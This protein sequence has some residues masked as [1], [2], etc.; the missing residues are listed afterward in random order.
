M[1]KLTCTLDFDGIEEAKNLADVLALLSR[2]YVPSFRDAIP[3][4]L[5]SASE[6]LLEQDENTDSSETAS[7]EN[8]ANTRVSH[9]QQNIPLEP[10]TKTETALRDMQG[11]VWNSDEHSTPPKLTAQG[12]WRRRRGISAKEVTVDNATPD[13]VSTTTA[14]VEQ[15]VSLKEYFKDVVN[16]YSE[17]VK[18][19]EK[20]P[21]IEIPEKTKDEI[22]SESVVFTEQELKDIADLSIPGVYSGF[23]YLTVKKSFAAQHGQQALDDSIKALGIGYGYDIP[24]ESMAR[25]H[26]LMVRLDAQ[27]NAKTKSSEPDNDIPF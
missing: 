7:S 24:Q 16:P 21:T 12:Q 22:P 8:T 9:S 25:H 19:F 15:P 2:G 27:Y 3:P 4:E 11:T 1:I 13:V 20:E 10:T 26:V 5:T 6:P 23:Q 14:S 17:Q 18:Q